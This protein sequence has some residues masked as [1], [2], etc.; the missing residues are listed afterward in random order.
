MKLIFVYNADSGV[1]NTVKDI[2]HKLFSPQTYDCFLCS[3]THDTFRENSEW[4]AF[5]NNS[6]AKM[7]FLYR[8]EFEEKYSK[9]MEY[10]VILKES[11]E[12]EVVI[13][14]DELASYSSLNNLIEAVKQFEVTEY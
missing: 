7:V 1:L 8:N 11:D 9:T 14:K 4:K 3:L 13:S 5:R 6:T 12:L 2:S 10:P